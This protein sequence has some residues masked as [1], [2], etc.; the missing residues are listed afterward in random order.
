MLTFIDISTERVT[1]CLVIIS[2]EFLSN[3]Q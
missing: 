3:Y 2:A 1:D